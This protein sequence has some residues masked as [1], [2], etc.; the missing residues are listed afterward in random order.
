MQ[1]AFLT[2][3]T[4]LGI[5]AKLAAL[6]RVAVGRMAPR[7]PIFTV[8]LAFSAVR[9]IVLMAAGGWAGRPH[10]YTEIWNATVG[11]SYGLEAAACVEA[12]W[13][14]ALHFRNVR[15]FGSAILAFAAALAAMLSFA[16]VASWSRWWANSFTATAI[17]EQRVGLMLITIALLSLFF[18]QQFSSVPI[19]P[20]AK[21]HLALLGLLF[22][23]TFAAGF[24]GQSERYLLRFLSNL[25]INL[26][27]VLAY[28][29]WAVTMKPSGEQLPFSPPPVLPDAEFAAAE[30]RD[31][32]AMQRTVEQARA[33]LENLEREARN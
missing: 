11:I 27:T 20:N 21:R 33:S 24:F 23:S 2:G 15:I 22:G 17:L 7:Y 1:A 31:R 5:F 25:A 6:M 10:P 13:I 8:M 12:F 19:R 30:I 4:F 9:S 28:A 26:G 18:F 32:A 3:L 14:L 16:A 29:L